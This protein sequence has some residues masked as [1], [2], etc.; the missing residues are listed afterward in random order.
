MRG[1]RFYQPCEETV[2]R[3]RHGDGIGAGKGRPD[4]LDS[5][6]GDISLHRDMY[7]AARQLRSFLLCNVELAWLIHFVLVCPVSF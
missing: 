7:R 3:S 2:F 6:Q 5:C 4:S 1:L